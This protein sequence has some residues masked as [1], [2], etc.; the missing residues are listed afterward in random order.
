MRILAI[1][2]GLTTGIAVYNEQN[3]LELSLT[4]SKKGIYRNS[5]LSKLVALCQPQIVLLEDLP[6]S[7][8]HK[9][10]RELHAHLQVWFRVAGYQLVDIRPGQWKGLVK[11]V[12]IPGQHAR[13]AATMVAWYINQVK[14][15]R[16]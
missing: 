11:R 14:S 7:N 12:E 10:T 8:I 3:D 1:D 13:D 9:E 4:V 16:R 2:P 5:F 6:R 15:D